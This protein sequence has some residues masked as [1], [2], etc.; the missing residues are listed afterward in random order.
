VRRCIG[1]VVVLC[2]GVEVALGADAKSCWTMGMLATGMRAFVLWL[3]PASLSALSVV[4]AS[5][6]V[7]WRLKAS[8]SAGGV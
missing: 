5:D 1:L 8:I 3:L 6:G 7:Y 2:R 4:P